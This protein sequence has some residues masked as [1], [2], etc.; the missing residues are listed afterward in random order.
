[1]TDARLAQSAVR[2]GLEAA[3]VLLAADLAGRPE[4]VL[5]TDADAQ[6]DGSA[7]RRL[8][9]ALRGGPGSGLSLLA[10]PEPFA[11]ALRAAADGERLPVVCHR[12]GAERAW[13]LQGAWA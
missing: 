3:I 13:V 12:G 1:M 11:E 8:T 5:L 2:A 6:P 10:P 7:S 9:L 4:A